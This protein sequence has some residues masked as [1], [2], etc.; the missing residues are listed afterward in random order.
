[1]LHARNALEALAARPELVKDDEHKS[2]SDQASLTAVDA[3]RALPPEDA[4]LRPRIAELMRLN[5]ADLSFRADKPLNE[6]H[7][8]AR[9]L[10][11]AQLED[12]KRAAPEEV[13]A[14]P[15]ASE[16][17]G[18]VAPDAARQPVE[19]TADGNAIGWQ[20]TGL[21]A[22]AGEVLTIR[23]LDGGDA[24]G[25]DV[26]IGCHTDRL[27]RLASWKR[28]PE[29]SREWSLEA[30]PAEETRVASPFGGLVYIIADKQAKGRAVRLEVR[31]AVRAPRF[32]RGQT[33]ITEWRETISAYPAP[34]AE[35]EGRKIIVSVP[36]SAVRSLDD[37]EALMTLW[38]RIADA[39]DELAT[40]DN[41]ERNGRPDR[42]AA[43]VQISAGY[44]HS[45]YP[46]MTHLDAVDEM[47]QAEK[48]GK[49]S[50][51]LFH[52]LGHNHQ[53]GDWT[54]GGT[55]EVTCNLFTLYA[56]EHACGRAWGE[57]H[58]ALKNRAEMIGRHLALG[59]PFDKWK[60]D[61]FLALQMYMQLVEGFGW[62][63][64]RK[65]FA[66]YRGLPRDQRPDS[67]DQK[68]DQWMVRFS[69]A[70][71]RNLGPFFEAW[72]VPTSEEARRSITDLPAWMPD[73]FPPE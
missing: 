56:M 25:F 53:S 21:Y 68:R 54:F 5:A 9:F 30:G 50:W 71:G 1:M 7:P 61:P 4:V 46:I 38:D 10:L 51:G 20:G 22:P 19:L 48:L 49:G 28:A 29:I 60:S 18:E 26:R 52:E 8:L 42:F 73:G 57:G 39:E 40:A 37:P 17:P 24:A 41:L 65:V 33:T 32:I 67:D 70:A 58:D 6:R 47:T 14:H 27:W 44:M 45:G 31:G 36:S 11:A 16:F 72:G 43:D 2:A 55:V 23:A 69:R 15:S 3:V 13:R 12:L 64:Y 63:T 66:E 35:L 59:A 62:E 34:W